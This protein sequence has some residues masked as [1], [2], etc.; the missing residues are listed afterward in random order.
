MAVGSARVRSRMP[1]VYGDHTIQT[2]RQVEVGS[3]RR[4]AFAQYAAGQYSGLLRMSVRLPVRRALSL[5]PFVET[6]HSRVTR[7]GFDETGAESVNLSG[8]DAFTTS[9][10]NTLV[11]VRTSSV[12]RLFGAR[13]E[14]TLSLAWTREG[15]DV[16][17]GMRAALSGMTTRRGFQ[18][19][20]LSGV[21]DSR[22]GAPSRPAPVW[23]SG[24]TAA[25][26]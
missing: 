3:V 8:V 5:A 4:Q 2:T 11:G 20:A 26:S 7:R 9:S 1:A 14:P 19:F 18:P 25:P 12:S 16:R 22:N 24:T 23:R 13:V 6:R 10:L 15:Q 21:A 17:S